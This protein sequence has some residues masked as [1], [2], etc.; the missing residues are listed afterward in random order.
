M[1]LRTLPTARAAAASVDGCE[2]RR[3][4]QTK[5]QAVPR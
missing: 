2:D 3:A 4:G 5:Q 1:P